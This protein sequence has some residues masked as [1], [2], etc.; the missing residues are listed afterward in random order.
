VAPILIGG[1]L[2]GAAGQLAKMIIGDPVPAADT[3][4]A[5]VSLASHYA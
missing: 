1:L 5:I 3:V 2:I 4:T